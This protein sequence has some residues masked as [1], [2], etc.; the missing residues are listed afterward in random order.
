MR[1]L[2]LLAV[3]FIG[4]KAFCTDG[5]TLLRWCEATF[6]DNAKPATLIN[7]GQC[8]GYIYASIDSNQA[9]MESTGTNKNPSQNLCFPEGGAENGQLA[10]IVIKYLKDHPEKLHYKADG[11]V[12]NALLTAFACK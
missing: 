4:P 11:L 8:F 3:L 7:E 6:E 5:N 1:K 2:L 10:R 9:W 12:Y